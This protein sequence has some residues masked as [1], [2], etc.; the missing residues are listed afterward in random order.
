MD[1]LPILEKIAVPRP[2]HSEAV[3]E[4]AVYIKELLTSQQIP[5]TT[6][7]FLVRPHQAML[8]GVSIIILS[9][10]FFLFI[11]SRRP[12]L[13]LISVLAILGVIILENETSFHAISSLIQRPGENVIIEFKSSDS[14]R[15]LVFAAHFDSKT[16]VLDH[17][18]RAI[19]LK[20]MPYILIIGILISILTYLSRKFNILNA[21]PLRGL[22]LLGGIGLVVFSCSAFIW[23]GGYIFLGEEMHSPGAVDDGASVVALL[24]M[25]DDIHRGELDIGRSDVTILL[26]DAEEVGFQGAYHYTKERF[27]EKAENLKKPVSLINLELLGQSGTLFHSQKTCSVFVCY[28]ADSE[29]ISR[30]RKVWSGI[31]DQPAVPLRKLND[32][33]FTFGKVGIPF[34]TIG[35]NGEPGL[36]LGKFHSTADNMDRVDAQNLQRMVQFLEKIVRSY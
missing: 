8:L 29:L 15:E 30:V 26:T 32:D 23:L 10:L 5:F 11:K 2:N 21:R 17:L 9:I 18:Q 27:G 33:S 13:A 7:E 3:R 25:A 14:Q 24:K 1:L 22:F 19:F 4:T 36:G 35:N 34:V 6:Q 31:S 20:L 28:K 16:D 12:V